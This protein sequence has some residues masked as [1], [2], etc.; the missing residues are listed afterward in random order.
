MT[1]RLPVTFIYLFYFL[2]EVIFLNGIPDISLGSININLLDIITILLFLIILFKLVITKFQIHKMDLP[3]LLFGVLITVSYMRGLQMF[4]LESATN[5]L[6]NTLYFYMTLLSIVV[7]GWSA[8]SLPKFIY[9]WGFISWLIFGIVLLRWAMVGTGLLQNSNW[10]A[11]GGGMVRV[12]NAA[13]TLFLLQTVIFALSIPKGIKLM[14]FQ[15]ALPW[16]LIPTIVVL[17][18]RT[19]WVILL[20]ILIWFAIKTKKVL[21]YLPLLTLGFVFIFM[22]IM[23]SLGNNFVFESITGSA[24]NL[25]TFNWRLESWSQLLSPTR[26]R[27]FTDYVIGQ[28]YGT[29]YVRYLYGSMYSTETSPHNFYIQTFLDVGAIGLILLL[30]FYLKSL[31]RL[32]RNQGILVCKPFFLLI[33]SQLLFFLAYPPN[34]EQGLL[35]GSAL[36]LNKSLDDH[37]LEP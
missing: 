21:I 17:Q 35:L 3:I 29:G 22:L 8:I 20:F 12:I 18:H 10:I 36:L 37:R 5:S 6:R 13:Q 9:A 15:R 33:V 24:Q 19:V 7:L 11:S 23:S 34:Y 30:Y 4:G 16:A 26:Y 14:P 31:I 1:N 28:P 27:S 2:L 32:K 25:Q